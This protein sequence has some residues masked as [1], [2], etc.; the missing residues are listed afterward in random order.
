MRRG[1]AAANWW[2]V[3]DKLGI[4]LGSRAD[5]AICYEFPGDHTEDADLFALLDVMIGQ[6]LAFI[7]VAR[8]ACGRILP[9]E[10]GVISRVV[11]E[12]RIHEPAATT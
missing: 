2:W 1:W 10:S 12:F 5:L 3:R 8:R 7:A 9:S 6:I 4:D 11:G